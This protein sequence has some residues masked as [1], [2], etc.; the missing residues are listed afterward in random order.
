MRYMILAA[1][2]TTVVSTA[3]A[4]PLPQK[5]QL[6]S[7][8]GP[9]SPFVDMLPG[10]DLLWGTGDEVSAPGRNGAGHSSFLAFDA[11]PSFVF[12]VFGGSWQQ[13]LETSDFTVV[14]DGFD[15]AGTFNC[16][17]FLG[18]NPEAVNAPFTASLTS[19]P[20]PSPS[21]SV[22]AG[23]PVG[24][25]VA[26]YQ[27]DSLNS[28]GTVFR[29]NGTSFVLFPG[30]DANLLFGA[31]LAAHFDLIRA[32]AALPADAVLAY[33][34]ETFQGIAGPSA[35]FTGVQAG[36]AYLAPIPVPSALPLAVSAL[37]TIGVWR[38]RRTEIT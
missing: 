3:H 14:F 37:A 35:G 21:A 16:P 26:S 5:W 22:N 23:V 29:R 4:V 38:A 13:T 15:I 7:D 36:T 10:P 34:A 1:M 25:Q 31:E 17:A 20:G 11:A 27:V 19:V 2:L 8:D 28:D 33:W 12:S 9:S 24:F 32:S 18:C 6:I 30:Q